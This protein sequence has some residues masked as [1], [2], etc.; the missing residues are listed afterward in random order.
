MTTPPLTDRETRLY[1]VLW[2]YAW[3]RRRYNAPLECAECGASAP[4]RAAVVHAPGC[5]FWG[6]DA[7][8]VAA[9]DADWTP[10]A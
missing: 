4:T 1:A 2:Q 10:T 9:L 8:T 3:S 7:A 6:L 5:V